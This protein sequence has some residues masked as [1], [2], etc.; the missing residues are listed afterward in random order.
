MGLQMA[1][2]LLR[3][4]HT[5]T[6]YNRTPD[7]AKA[8]VSEGAIAVDTPGAACKGEIVATMLADDNAL[9]QVVFGEQGDVARS[10]SSRHSC[11]HEHRQH[12]D[13]TAS[14]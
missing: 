10:R 11:R 2:N 6:V 8:L 4:G 13:G 9:E 14:H 12:S 3:A 1:R 7:K 5:V